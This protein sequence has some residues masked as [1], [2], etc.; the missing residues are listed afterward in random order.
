MLILGCPLPTLAARHREHRRDMSRGALVALFAVLV[1]AMT[2]SLSEARQLW[3]LDLGYERSAITDHGQPVRWDTA[4]VQAGRVVAATG[5]WFVWVERQRRAALVDVAVSATGYRRL[6]DWTVAG[7]LA[8]GLDPQFLYRRSIDAEV[9][10]RVVGTTVLFLGYR[11]L[12][13]AASNV[14][15]LQPGLAWHHSRGEIQGRLYVTHR[16][17]GEP[18][19]LTGMVSTWFDAHG[20]VRLS[21]SASYGDRISDVASL[22]SSTAIARAV[23]VRGRV[24]VTRNN[25]LEIGGGVVHEAPSFDQLTLAL[26]YRRTF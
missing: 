22:A 19:S 25:F 3:S 18:I 14:H 8:A 4:R 13:F 16:D 7:G 9:S 11:M 23:H 21:A 1:S 6:G 17:A 5:G 12:D 2:P 26:T 24:A 15:Q 10:R 20:R